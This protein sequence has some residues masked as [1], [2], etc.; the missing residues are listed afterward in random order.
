[1][2]PPRNNSTDLSSQYVRV[3]NN[4]NSQLFVNESLVLYGSYSPVDE[5][6][7][8]FMRES[9]VQTPAWSSFKPWAVEIYLLPDP[10]L[11]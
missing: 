9:L 2:R 7:I 1:M 6:K 3:F 10:P 4:R 11:R 5:R 8:A